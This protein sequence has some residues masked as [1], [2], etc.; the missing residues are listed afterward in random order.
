MDCSV[1]GLLSL[2]LL[3]VMGCR[4]AAEGADLT[5][6]ASALAGDVSSL[7]VPLAPFEEDG[8]WQPEGK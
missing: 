2:L 8:D 6:Q 7:R 3:V 4:Q 5:A 1:R